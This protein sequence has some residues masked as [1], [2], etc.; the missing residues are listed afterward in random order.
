VEAEIVRIELELGQ[1]QREAARAHARALVG[2]PEGAR[3]R[4]KFHQLLESGN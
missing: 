2:R 1:G 4:H 3:Y